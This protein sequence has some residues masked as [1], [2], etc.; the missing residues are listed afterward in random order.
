ME[1]SS[2][3]LN[4]NKILAKVFTPNMKG[5]DPDEVDKFLDDIIEDYQ[6][7]DRYYVDSKNYIIQLETSNRRIKEENQRLEQE[8]AMLKKRFEGLKPSDNPSQENIE[9]LTRI[10]KL[11]SELY[12]LG[13]N[14]N[15]I[16]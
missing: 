11:E 13:I 16:K 5:Y 12:K 1:E 9:Y 3:N 7:F 8:K 15:D 14:P 2:F 4:A 6:A 10:R